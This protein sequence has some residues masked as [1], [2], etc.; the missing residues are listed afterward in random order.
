M[1]FSI[2]LVSNLLTM[3]RLDTYLTLTSCQIPTLIY[4]QAME[5]PL[6]RHST[7]AIFW[8]F[9]SALT[10]ILELLPRYTHCV[11]F[12]IVK[13]KSLNLSLW[14]FI[15]L[16]WSWT[17]FWVKLCITKTMIYQGVFSIATTIHHLS[18]LTTSSGKY[19]KKRHARQPSRPADIEAAGLTELFR[20]LLKN[21][22]FLRQNKSTR[23]F[24]AS[25]KD[26]YKIEPMGQTQGMNLPQAYGK[27]LI[28][29]TGHEN[30]NWVDMSNTIL[31]FTWNSRMFR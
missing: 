6:T 25:H 21:C 30:T 3:C 7:V 1:P 10:V 13:V 17:D 12:W 9:V 14:L 29:N 31:L 2:W 20:L 8:T 27:V 5:R 11:A 4:V 23:S 18:E 19:L 28:S 24:T 15:E 22:S 26:P 16:V